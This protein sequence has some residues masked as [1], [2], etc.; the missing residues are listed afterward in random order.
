VRPLWLGTEQIGS[1]LLLFLPRGWLL[2]GF[3]PEE[4]CKSNNL[5]YSNLSRRFAKGPEDGGG[6]LYWE[7][8]YSCSYCGA[9]Y[10]K[11]CF[12]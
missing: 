11:A 4:A 8:C 1:W 3:A 2:L 10:L 9:Y 5:H 7:S 6:V 12:N